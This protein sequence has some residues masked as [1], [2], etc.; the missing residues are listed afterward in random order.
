MR[1]I[2]LFEEFK[3][4]LTTNEGVFSEIDIVGQESET[5]ADFVRDVKALLSKRAANPEVA[6]DDNFIED[7][8]KT[9]FDSEGNKK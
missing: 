1:K 2:K 3:Q 5:K 7:L 4:E 6:N 8:A 9:Y